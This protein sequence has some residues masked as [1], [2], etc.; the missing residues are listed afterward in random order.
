MVPCEA[1]GLLLG[2]LADRLLPGAALERLLAERL[3]PAAGRVAELAGEEADDRVGDVEL[4][5]VL[6]ELLGV[7]ADRDEVQ[8]EVADHLGR[9]ASP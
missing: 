4:P 2:Q 8:G 9:R 5:G 6:L 1:L 3:G 7:G